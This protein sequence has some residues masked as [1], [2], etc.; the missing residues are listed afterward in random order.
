MKRII[1]NTLKF[2]DYI[3]KI[4][5]IVLCENIFTQYSKLAISAATNQDDEMS[6]DEFYLTLSDDDLKEMSEEDIHSITTLELIGRIGKI[7]PEKLSLKQY[8]Q[9]QKAYKQ[10]KKVDNS[11]V[12]D[13]L[14][15]LKSCNSISYE[16]R[17]SKTNAFLID[18]QGRL[19][20][21]ECLDILH[22]LKFGDF[23][24]ARNSY[25]INT[26]GDILMIFRPHH[27]WRTEDGT[28]LKDI[29]IYVKLDVDATSKHAVALVSMHEAEFE[30]IVPQRKTSRGVFWLING[31]L[32]AY[33]FDENSTEGIAKSGN[34]Y[35]HKELWESV[36]PKRC[37]KSFDYYP[38]GRVE[39]TSKGK[40]I[41]Y[42]SPHIDEYYVPE[43][44]SQFGLK[45]E[46]EIRY[47]WSKHYECHLDDGYDSKRR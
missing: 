23:R 10:K 26:I 16:R 29:V 4:V 27:D 3:D 8:K 33:P 41:I 18:S 46:P 9:L 37:N 35:N 24:E 45:S 47:D 32:Y 25:D 2:S 30:D 11:F 15:K 42:M 20:E 22:Q 19:R 17:H 1:S 5:H 36:K 34:T 7:A 12:M 31:E 28:I 38:R 13:F 6:D 14:K 44:R 43:I 40:P 39:I 21:S